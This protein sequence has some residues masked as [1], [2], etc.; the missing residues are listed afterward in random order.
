LKFLD[1]M[2]G[3]EPALTP[4][5]LIYQRML[6][7]DPVEAAEQAENYLR[8]QPLMT[9][10]EEILVEGLKL[11]QAD[12]DRGSL[13]DERQAR[14][15]DAVAVIVDDLGSHNDGVDRKLS[16]PEPES[17]AASPLAHIVRAEESLERS[18][19][20]LPSNWRCGKP[21]LCVPGVSH[22]DEAFTLIVAQSVE[23]Q[24]IGVRSEHWGALSMA[25]IFS[26]DTEGVELVCLCYLP[27]V[28][29]AKI[30][31]VVRRLRRKAPEAFIVVTLARATVERDFENSIRDSN[32]VV[33]VSGSLADTRAKVLEIAGSIG[34]SNP[35]LMVVASHDD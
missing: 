25:R 22:L 16:P 15:R 10:Y 8:D 21:V 2:L 32:R 23:R 14:I 17:Q 13:D 18:E 5:E 1:V 34:S 9:Y 26:L 28:T 4:P 30:R 20:Q 33:P 7:G 11:A 19:L 24:G 6:A 12:A 27:A 31:Y 3:D 29:S 35:K